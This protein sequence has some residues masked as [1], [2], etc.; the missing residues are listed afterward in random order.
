MFQAIH[1]VGWCGDGEISSLVHQK[2]LSL[3]GLQDA[4]EHLTVFAELVEAK[5]Y[6]YIQHAIT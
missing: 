4:H 2:R 5:A 3:A 6:K 1:S